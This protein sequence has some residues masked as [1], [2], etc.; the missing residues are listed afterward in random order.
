V[1]VCVCVRVC[2]HVY[3]CVYACVFAR[4]CVRVCVCVCVCVCVHSVAR[5]GWSGS[6]VAGG[7]LVQ[8]LGFVTHSYGFLMEI[9]RALLQTCIGLFC[10]QSGSQAESLCI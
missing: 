6:A 1:Y 4:V 9:C 5:F 10:G 7:V 3:V 2:L 8:Y